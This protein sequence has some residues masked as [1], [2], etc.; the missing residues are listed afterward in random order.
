MGRAR[1]MEDHADDKLEMAR[2]FGR[3]YYPDHKEVEIEIKK[4]FS[5]MN[6][7]EIQIDHMTGKQVHE[8]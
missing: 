4:D 7:I 2:S 5:R 8:K 6:M 3:K 1:L